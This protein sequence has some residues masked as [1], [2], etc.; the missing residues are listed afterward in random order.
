MGILFSGEFLEMALKEKGSPEMVHSINDL[1]ETSFR[2][3]F[4]WEIL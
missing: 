2:E 4:F 1:Q 3:M